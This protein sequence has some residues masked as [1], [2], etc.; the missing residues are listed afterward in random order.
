[1]SIPRHIIALHAASLLAFGGLAVAATVMAEPAKPH[2]H[3]D[4][5]PH[6]VLMNGEELTAAEC[7]AL[8]GGEGWE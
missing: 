2:W 6:A 4:S 3:D 7:E 1:M 5:T 8:F